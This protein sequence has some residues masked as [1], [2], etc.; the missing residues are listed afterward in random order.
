MLRNREGLSYHNLK[1][2][3]ERFIEYDILH[4]G[5]IHGAGSGNVVIAGDG[6]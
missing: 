6:K 1:D 4:L 3:R 5:I 2:V